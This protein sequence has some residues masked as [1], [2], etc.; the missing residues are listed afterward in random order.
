MCCPLHV[1]Q[2]TAPAALI[3]PPA[4]QAV[5]WTRGP[6]AALVLPTLRRFPVLSYF[7][8]IVRGASAIR[9]RVQS[10]ADSRLRCGWQDDRDARA[11]G[12]L[13]RVVAFAIHPP[14]PDVS[15]PLPTGAPVVP[16]YTPILPPGSGRRVPSP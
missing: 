12:R 4:V 15:A 14:Q 13:Q 2:E 1:V 5:F 16:S 3:A 10:L 11:Q 8:H 9:M 7:C 6:G